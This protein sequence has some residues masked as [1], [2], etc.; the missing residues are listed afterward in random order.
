MDIEENDIDYDKKRRER[1]RRLREAKRRQLLIRRCTR[2][3]IL[4][5]VC[6]TVIVLGGTSLVK[7][8]A[9]KT[10]GAAGKA[11][12]EVQ[13][14]TPDNPNEAMR[15]PIKDAQNADK[16]SSLSTGWQVDEQGSWY[17][18]SDGS[19]FVSGWKEIE[20]QKYFFDDK[21]YMTVGWL[22]L[23]G[24]DYYFNE[25]GQYDATV[26]RPMVALTFD[27][28]PGKFT[29]RLLDCLEANNAKATFF[30]LG[31]NIE[32]F[33]DAVKREKALGMEIGNHTYDHQILTKV[34]IS[35]VG[36]E[37]TKTNDIFKN[38]LGEQSTVMRPPGGATNEEVLTQINMPIVLWSIDTK[39]WKTRDV[40]NTIDVTL[41]NVKDGSIVL[42]HDIHE[43]TVAAAEQIIP[44]LIEQGYK[45]VTVSELAKAKGIDLNN[46]QTYSY[47]GEGT[48]M[49]E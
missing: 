37:V 2:I 32:K 38:L 39:D 36:P 17:Q 10:K 30:M 40:Q 48:Q 45:L 21:G 23:E 35:E 29:D 33:P 22:E 42:L 20:G 1:I 8:I 41:N 18:N 19:F 24:Q 49:V 26:K 28:G 16:I 14:E 9:K 15:Q 6:L 3:G 44:A 31:Q 5:I 11:V 47:F 13:A 7:A 27:D 34:D 12:V 4:A 46:N 43:T 25:N